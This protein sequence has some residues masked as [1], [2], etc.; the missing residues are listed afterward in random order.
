MSASADNSG[1]PV[2][3]IPYKPDL[4]SCNFWAFL[5]P[6]CALKGQK[7]GSEREVMQ[8]TGHNPTQD[9]RKWPTTH[10]CEVGGAAKCVKLVNGITFEEETM[11][12]PLDASD[13]Q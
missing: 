4:V 8:A 11:L 7:F 6:E 12:K 3:H 1:A 5:V 2:K 10:V 9:I 13:I